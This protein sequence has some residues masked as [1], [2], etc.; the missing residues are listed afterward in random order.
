MKSM[1]STV[2]R[3]NEKGVLKILG[4]EA[5]VGVCIMQGG[6][7]CCFNSS[8][9]IAT[10]YTADELIGKDSLAIVAP[11]DRE[12]VKENTI[13]MLKGK[14]I[15]P[16]QFRVIHKDGSIVWIMATVKSIQYHGRRAT[17]GSY[18]E[19]TE[20]KQ[21]EEALKEREE[22]YRELADSIT[23]VFFAMDEHLRYTYWNKAS[24]ILTGIRAEDAVGKSLREIFP[25]MPGV[26]RAEKMYCK[27]L[28][29]QQ[30]QTFVNETDIGGRHYI[31]EISAYPT[32]DGISVFVRDITEHKLAEERLKES[33]Q[34]YRL[35]F[36]NSPDCIAQIDR[37]GRYLA[38]NPAVSKS[39]GVPLEELNGKLVSKVVPREVAQH[40]VRMLKK[41]LDEWQTQTFEDE[42]AGRYF[43]HIIIP[44][45]I[46]DQK[47]GVQVITRDITERKKMEEALRQ[48][49]EKYRVLFDN[50]VIG[51]VVLDAETMK[52]VMVNQAAL[53]IF[54][55][56][57]VDEAIVLNPLEFIV[58]E[59]RKRALENTTKDLFEQDLRRTYEFRA[60][61]K[62]GREIWISTTS[63][64]IIHEGRLAGLVAF[65]DITERKGMEEALKQSEERYR[66]ILDE[67]GDS[68]F[69]V[70]LGG[71]LTFVNSATCRALGYS[72]EELIGTSYKKTTL[73]DDIESVFRIFNE[74]Y[75]TGKPSK[76]CVWTIVC[77]DGTHRLIEHSALPLRNDRGE[78]IG[79]RGVGRDITERKQAE[80]KLRQSKEKYRALF[81]SSVIGAVVMDAETMKVV[82]CNQAAARMMGFSS[83]EEAI[84]INP[85][86]FIHPEYKDKAIGITVKEMFEQDLRRTHEYQVVNKDG[87]EGWVSVTGARIMH[88]GRLAG[89][90]TITD[91]TERKQAVEA[92]RQ[93]EEKYRTILEEMEDAYFEVDLGGHLTFVNNSVCRD[94]GYSR[95]ELIGMS[96]KD[97][98]VEEDI[99]SVFQVFNEVYRTG[100][101]NK[102]F[103]WKTIRK[104][105]VQGFA[106]T[107]VSPLRN[108]KG[109]IIGFRGVGRDVTERKQTEEKLQQSRE[110][111][112]ALFDSSVIGA[113][114]VDAETM[115][116][117]MANQATLK[118]FGFSSPEAGVN[119]LDFIPPEDRE[120]NI[121]RLMKE[122]FEKD[123]RKSIDLPA[124]TKDGKEI[125]VSVTG[126][127]ITHK[128][129][130]A[131]LL[132][133]ADI[134]ERKQAEEKLRQSEE[135]YK[136]LFDSS[137]IGMYV[138]DVETMKVVMGNR[139]AAEMAGL[140]SVGEGLGIN[141]FDFV[142][143]EAREQVLEMAAKEFEQDLRRTHELPVVAKDGGTGWISISSAR[144]MHDGR[145]AALVSFNDITER[146]RM[147]EALRQSE[148]NYRALFDSSVIGTFVLD[149]ENM[150]VVMD[151]QAA[152]KMF[153]FGSVEEA[154]GINLLDFVPPEDKERYLE[155]ATKELFEQDLRHSHEFRA[156][157]KD[158]RKIWISITGARIMHEGRLADLVSFTDITE[159][160]QAEEALRQSE[161]NYRVLFDSSVI[162]TIVLDAE[163]L[164]VAMVNQAAVKMFGFSSAEEALGIDPLV[165]IR[166]DDRERIFEG[167]LKALFEQDSREVYEL[168]ALTKDGRE[169]WIN[170]T[171]SKIMHQ[172]R[173]AGLISFTD[174]TEEKRQRERLM[175]TDRL[176]SLGELASGTAHELNNPLTSIVGFS[177]LLMEKEVPDDIRE[178]LKLI[179]NEAQRAARVTKN[180]LTFARKHAPVKQRTQINS[181]IDDV[182]RLRAHMHKTNGIEVEQQLA[183]NLPE[184]MVDYFQMQQVFINIIIN[185]EYFMTEAHNGGTL[186][187]TAKKQNNTVVISFADDGPGIPPEN[188]RR[189]FDPFF[190]T[191]EAG[192]GTGLGLS[193]CH[194]IVAE[195]G[196]QM[197]AKSQLGK[198][199][200]IFV[201]LPINE[202]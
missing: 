166:P 173:L 138:L 162:G 67:M 91:I 88:E 202:R 50:A 85:I 5:P 92:L 70:D 119:P 84:G 105:G 193:I 101:P 168:R 95:E 59:D 29:T 155:I 58:P 134:T 124:V 9:P 3:T 23:D 17:L 7:F 22:K 75:R 52:V 188:M 21:L 163:T 19:V 87:R 93:S 120:K 8:F 126:A 140:S 184:I 86:D 61:T 185:A 37:E 47:E 113:V 160:K 167:A 79:F 107:S 137:V 161:E 175:M 49:E 112:R 65:A 136:T 62:D 145:L 6:K 89:L 78:I 118:M 25:D 141:P 165:F 99:E 147:E 182:L 2:E 41:A 198:G 15:S 146:K 171:G 127:R 16:Y 176:A 149:A 192:K 123:S 148:E 102:G 164:K 38:A 10:G 131:A 97:F 57:S 56:S 26:R 194:G 199:A 1:K 139:A 103:P 151:N 170:A 34:R 179:N 159:R 94:L 96:Y 100:V 45:K 190:T 28:K 129:R 24:E 111:Y 153:G 115:K 71:H 46:S 11:E 142:I 18:M 68:Y 178:D 83:V 169:I 135:N 150:K 36:E 125:W 144:I 12:T 201:E 181:I 4:E 77:K 55:F 82:M 42:R 156:I 158:G 20:R 114:V 200:T 31:F 76:S 27:V 132:S 187:V 53:N 48:S 133:F 51:M 35:L 64:R 32:Q 152:A 74:V 66:T 196:G 122:V 177:Q 73:E 30:P 183:P 180:L 128:G 143:P 33:E 110:N 186:T 80:E 90:V 39:L 121:E 43:H 40:R 174:V 14:L 63:A 189:I 81:E 104:D 172:G 69:E 108:E 116:V 154:I 157:T 195:H 106:E 72:K 44:T 98:T 109:E 191:K 13:K 54:G 197:Y 130:L 60:V 117:V